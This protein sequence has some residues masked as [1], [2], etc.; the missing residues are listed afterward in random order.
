MNGVG[1]GVSQSPL[2]DQFSL[3]RVVGDWERS[4]GP[5]QNAG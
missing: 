1:I 4:H 5:F 2:F 3:F